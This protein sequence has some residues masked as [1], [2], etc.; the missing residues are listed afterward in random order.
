MNTMKQQATTPESS[1]VPPGTGAI[2]TETLEL[3][4]A[5]A[6][7]DATANPDKKAMNENR[8]A[9]GERILYP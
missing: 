2:D 7:K 4:E 3:L 1:P 9:C 5:W 6:R 8:A